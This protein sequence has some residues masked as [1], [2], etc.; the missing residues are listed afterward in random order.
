MRNFLTVLFTVL[1][2]SGVF[3]GCD[4]IDSNAPSVQMGNPDEISVRFDYHA[5]VDTAGWEGP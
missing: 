2:V 5:D 4:F 3:I 1:A